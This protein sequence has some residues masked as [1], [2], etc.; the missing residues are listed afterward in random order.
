MALEKAPENTHHPSGG[1]HEEREEKSAADVCVR[2]HR[3]S[4]DG[5]DPGKVVRQH[6]HGNVEEEEEDTLHRDE[7]NSDDDEERGVDDDCCRVSTDNEAENGGARR[8]GQMRERVQAT[9]PDAERSD[10]GVVFGGAPSANEGVEEVH[11]GSLSEK[12]EI[13]IL[14]T[15]I[16]HPCSERSKDSLC[17]LAREELALLHTYEEEHGDGRMQTGFL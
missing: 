14:I 17:K 11:P 9:S 1:L 3:V 16:T 7:L 10:H 4:R 13:S 8:V 6:V 12:G 15:I 2:R 5:V